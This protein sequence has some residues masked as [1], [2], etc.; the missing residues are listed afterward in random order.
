MPLG[1]HT[2]PVGAPTGD[3]Q[4]A[5]G[6]PAHPAGLA[7]PPAVRPRCQ[8]ISRTP[9]PR[10]RRPQPSACVVAGRP[11]HPDAEPGGRP[12]D[13]DVV[14]ETRDHG[15]AEPLRQESFG[16]VQAAIRTGVAIIGPAAR[17]GKAVR[18]LPPPG[19]VSLV[20][21]GGL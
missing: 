19:T 7:A 2:V 17:R 4:P 14:S 20:I 16:V 1:W 18:G 9:S 21:M 13:L 6:P 5:S 15:E 11:A 12:G 10:P 8:R 3:R